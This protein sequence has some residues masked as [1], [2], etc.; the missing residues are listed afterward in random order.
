MKLTKLFSQKKAVTDGYYEDS[1]QKWLPIKNI[2]NGVVLLKDGRY[3]KVMEVLPVNF[4]LKSETE[5]QNIIY[6]FASYLKIAP[7]KMQIR[8]MTQKADIGAH[9][10]ML[11]GF[12]QQEENEACRQMIQDEMRFVD[13]LAYNVAVKKRFF[14]IFEFMPSSFDRSYSFADVVRSL[15]DEETKSRRYLAQCGLEVLSSNDAFITDLFYSLINKNTV[16]DVKPGK[17]AYGMLDEIQGL[18]G[19]FTENE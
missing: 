17:I 9:L 3:V 5:Q 10:D 6:Y 18:E 13:G 16:K 11:G 14:V 7:D 2:K 19:G 8:V 4:Y 1:T 15:E 12:Y